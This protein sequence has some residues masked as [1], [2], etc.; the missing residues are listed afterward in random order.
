MTVVTTLRRDSITPDLKPVKVKK[1]RW[2][3]K[4]PAAAKEPKLPTEEVEKPTRTEI[5]AQNRQFGKSVERQ[6]AKIVGGVRTP[7]SGAIKNSILNLEGDIRVRDAGGKRDLAVLECKGTS[8]ITPKG[9]KTFTLKKSV[10]DQAHREADLVKAI[11][12]VWLH[13]KQGEYMDDYIIMRS[14]H[15]T[16]LLDYAKTGAALDS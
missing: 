11:G 3:A 13:W 16:R 2:G 8:G 1:E 5:N 6:I 10:L 7:G 9:D 12:A 14:S 15:F 4:K